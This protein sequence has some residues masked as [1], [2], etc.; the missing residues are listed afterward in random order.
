MIKEKG[1]KEK[2]KIKIIETRKIKQQIEAKE[3]RNNDKKEK[4]E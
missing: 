4:I 3:Q 1:I 2:G